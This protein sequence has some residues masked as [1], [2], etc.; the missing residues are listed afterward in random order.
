MLTKQKYVLMSILKKYNKVPEKD[1]FKEFF[2]L[3][4]KRD[5]NEINKYPIYGK[6]ILDFGGLDNTYLDEFLESKPMFESY[7]KFIEFCLEVNNK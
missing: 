2:P 6:Q 1:K 4:L 3:F 7:E 5:I